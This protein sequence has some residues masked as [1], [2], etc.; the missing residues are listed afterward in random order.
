MKKFLTILLVM[1][2]GIASA[3]LVAC[4]TSSSI[5]GN[6]EGTYKFYSIEYEGT[7]TV[8]GTSQAIEMGLT[9]EAI[10]LVVREDGTATIA[11]SIISESYTGTWVLNGNS[12]AMT[13]DGDTQTFTFSNG[14]MTIHGDGEVVVLKKV[15]S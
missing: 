2:L 13:A 7:T 14:T 3:C 5:D 15:N 11:N 4:S 10:T 6:V 12:F 1:V 8:V 9:E